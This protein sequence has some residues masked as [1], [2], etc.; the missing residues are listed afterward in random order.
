MNINFQVRIMINNKVLRRLHN[1]SL[2]VTAEK[3]S[4]AR[5]EVLD[6]FFLRLYEQ[7]RCSPLTQ[8]EYCKSP[9]DTECL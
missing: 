6:K 7:I 8:R 2:K 9:I 4:S 1:S 3:N 5:I